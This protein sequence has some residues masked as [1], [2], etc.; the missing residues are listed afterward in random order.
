MAHLQQILI[1]FGDDPKENW[2]V[3]KLLF[4]LKILTQK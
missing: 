4:S 1:N 2:M 3:T